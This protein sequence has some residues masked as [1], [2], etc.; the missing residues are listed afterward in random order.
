VLRSALLALLAVCVAIVG[1]A[2]S[3]WLAIGAGGTIGAVEVGGWTSLPDRGTPT[4]DPY[5]RAQLARDGT[6]ALG[7]A[8]GLAF[9]TNRDSQG[10]QLSRECRYALSGTLPAARLWTLHAAT[11]GLEPFVGPTGRTAALNAYGA[12]YGREGTVDVAIG[13]PAAPGN[14]LPVTGTGP[15]VLVLMLYDTPLAGDADLA[16]TALP[17]ITLEGCDG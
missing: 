5:A 2:G 12:L 8:E 11:P 9:T 6:L 7:H 3:V 17:R 16:G 13:A 14:W 15:M 4:S 10:R 1:G